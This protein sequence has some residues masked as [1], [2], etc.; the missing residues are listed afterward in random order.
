MNDDW[1]DRPMML[2]EELLEELAARW[3]QRGM[4]IATSLRPSLDDE[5][6]DELTRPLGITLPREA[7]TWWRWHD[8]ASLDGRGSPSMGPLKLYSPLAD[9]VRNT[10]AIR[11]TMRGV[12]GE[13]D[14]AWRYS[15]LAMNAGGDTTVIDC[16]VG[17]DDPVPARHYRFEEPET[18]A[19]GVPSIGTL[20][21]LYIAA[22]DRGVWAYDPVRGVWI[23]DP[24]KE[25]P[26]TSDL[27]LT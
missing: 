17:F 3:R 2:S 11:E 14:P 10:A 5:E 9:A 20:V 18:G 15:W 7:R 1:G 23:G 21:T 16:S 27:H 19:E 8:G 26:A 4:P 22:Y 25:D 13:L 12:N 6:M 24:S